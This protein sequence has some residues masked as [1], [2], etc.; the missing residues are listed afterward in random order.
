MQ[1]DLM[2]CLVSEQKG[3]NR[4]RFVA[5]KQGASWRIVDSHIRNRDG[6]PRTERWCSSEEQARELAATLNQER[7]DASLEPR[8]SI[9]GRQPAGPAGSDRP[10]CGAC[11]SR[12]ADMHG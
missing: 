9:C 1:A 12:M 3:H 5:E 10:M 8:C 4:M 2:T 7:P 6:S 11:H